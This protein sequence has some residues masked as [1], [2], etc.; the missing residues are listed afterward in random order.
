MKNHKFLFAGANFIACRRG[1]GMKSTPAIFC[2]FKKCKIGCC[3]QCVLYVCIF[4]ACVISI[5][6]CLGWFCMVCFGSSECVLLSHAVVRYRSAYLRIANHICVYDGS[7][8]VY[9]ITQRLSQASGF[10]HS[11]CMLYFMVLST[12]ITVLFRP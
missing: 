1:A 6:R 4:R 10:W 8:V 3:V 11:R 2:I 9:A 12:S 7:R 5:I